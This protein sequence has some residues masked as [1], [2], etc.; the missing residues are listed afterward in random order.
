MKNIHPSFK[1][2]ES[3]ITENT[4]NFRLTEKNGKYGVIFQ[5]NEAIAFAMF[6]NEDFGLSVAFKKGVSKEYSK[7]DIVLATF[8]ATNNFYGMH[9]Y[10]VTENNTIFNAHYKKFNEL[11]D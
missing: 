9:N 8:N 2:V 7:K 1:A 10:R 11:N 3:T 4:L 6:N 5:G